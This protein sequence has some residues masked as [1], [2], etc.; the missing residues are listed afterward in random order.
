MSTRLTRTPISA[1]LCPMGD[2]RSPVQK[3]NIKLSENTSTAVEGVNRRVM[4]ETWRLVAASEARTRLL[5]ELK[6]L[7]LGVAEI[8]EFGISI[9]SKLRSSFYRSKVESGETVS[10]EVIRLI[11]K[12]KLKDEKKHLEELIRI[13]NREKRELGEKLSRNSRPFRK[14]LRDMRLE[15]EQVRAEYKEQERTTFHIEA[16]VEDRQLYRIYQTYKDFT[17]ND[18][19]GFYRTLQERTV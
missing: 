1:T 7:D 16:N 17:G 15:A 14:I 13:R 11:M 4:A 3:L 5:R 12:L 18:C 19:I 8:E 10:Q 2:E 9:N 6:D